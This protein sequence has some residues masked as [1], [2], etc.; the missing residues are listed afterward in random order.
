MPFGLW[1]QSVP[2]T[3]NAQVPRID[4]KLDGGVRLSDLHADKHTYRKCTVSIQGKGSFANMGP[5]ACNIKGRGNSTWYG[6]VKKPYRLKFVNKV[7][8]FGL[9]GGKSWVLLA[10]SLGPA[11]LNNPVGMFIAQQVGTVAPNH[12][13][14]VELY[15][16]NEYLGLYS[17]T[18]QVGISANSVKTEKEEN[19]ALLELDEYDGKQHTDN[20]YKLPMSVKDPDLDHY[21]KVWEKLYKKL[22]GTKPNKEAFIKEKT[23][24]FFSTLDEEFVKLSQ[25]VEQ[26]NAESI[27][28]VPSLV[29]YFFVYDLIGNLELLHPKSVYLHRQNIFDGQS[30]WLF[31]PVWDCDWAYG[32][33]NVYQFCVSSPE[34]DFFESKNKQKPGARFFYQ[35]MREHKTIRQQYLALWKDYMAKNKLQALKAY[36]DAYQAFIQPAA[37]RD[38]DRWV[39]QNPKFLADYAPMAQRMK[40]WLERRAQYI[41]HS[42]EH[43]T[44]APHVLTIGEEGMATV[45]LPYDWRIPESMT[46]HCVKVLDRQRLDMPKVLDAGKVVARHVPV[47]VKAPSGRYPLLAARGTET[48]NYLDGCPNDLLGALTQQTIVAESG[49]RVYI[50]ANDPVGGLGFYFQKNTAGQFVSGLQYH[51]YL[52]VPTGRAPTQGFSFGGTLSGLPPSGVPQALDDAPLYDLSGRRVSQPSQGIYLRNGQKVVR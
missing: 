1:A 27:I 13:I 16:N 34:F 49:H 19:C 46:V 15:V 48:P 9:P 44:P 41:V 43:G 29:R 22:P 7:S 40:S 47:L 10:N 14:P 3:P 23:D 32:Y 42:L 21:K 39:S 11:Q 33:E 52:S 51:A 17:F 28:D 12:M 5:E 30:R 8:P 18:E 35:L 25:A 38:H 45:C 37:R 6:H 50:L 24:R 26:G 2:T 20:A 4:I 36:I 31:G